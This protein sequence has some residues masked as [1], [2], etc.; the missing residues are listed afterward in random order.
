VIK[1]HDD[2]IVE[3]LV[4]I[5]SEDSDSN[6]DP[7]Y[8]RYDDGGVAEDSEEDSEEVPKGDTPH[9]HA[10]QLEPELDEVPQEEV[11]H[12]VVKPHTDTEDLPQ[13]APALAPLG[14]PHLYK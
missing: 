11:P 14:F 12:H 13:V 1:D 2:F 6:S 4:K 10:P 3:L 8:D 5:D 9:E 7:N